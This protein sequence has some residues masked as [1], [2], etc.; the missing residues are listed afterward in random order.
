MT[1]P[2]GHQLYPWQQAVWDRF[3]PV[4]RGERAGHA[5]LLTGAPG[6]GKRHLAGVILRALLCEQPDASRLPC[7]QCRACIQVA[8]GSH[9]DHSRL[10]PP[11]PGKTIGVDAVREFCRRLYTT[12]QF[13]GGRIGLIDPADRLTVQAANSLLKALEEPPASSRILLLTDRRDRV[14]PTIRSRCQMWRVDRPDPA[15]VADWLATMPAAVA[16]AMPLA[17]NAP[18]QALTLA[19]SPVVTEQGTLF[20]DLAGLL[21]ARRDPVSIA[22]EWQKAEPGWVVD[23]LYR[24]VA[25]LLK[26]TSGAPDDTL[27][28]RDR[29]RELRRMA[30]LLDGQALR[31]LPPT[32]T[33]TRRLL[34]ASVD[35]QLTLESLAIAFLDCRRREKRAA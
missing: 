21:V 23:W 32:L 6:I 33:H 4:L 29:A 19:D 1:E 17:R 9:P 16:D 26:L 25:D 12:P 20:E 7:G 10:A 11:E 24:V 8:A 31:R 5:L 27:V 28:F 18:L 14:L 13:A 34:E 15:G 30:E 22:A 3:A 2:A 35:R